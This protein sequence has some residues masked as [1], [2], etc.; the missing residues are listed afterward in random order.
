[1]RARLTRRSSGAAL[2]FT[3]RIPPALAPVLVPVPALVLVLVLVPV[4]VL[5]LPRR[6]SKSEGGCS[7]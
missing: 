7:G 5:G 1:M 6:N 4:L 3:R 2:M